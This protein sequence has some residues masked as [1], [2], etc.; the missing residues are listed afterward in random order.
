[1]F[2][3]PTVVIVIL[4]NLQLDARTKLFLVMMA[5]FVQMMP[6]TPLLVATTHPLSVTITTLVPMIPAIQLAV[7]CIPPLIVLMM[8]N[9]RPLVATVP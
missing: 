6:A 8:M 5:I 4:A 9:V 1:L 7:V 3:L 2:V